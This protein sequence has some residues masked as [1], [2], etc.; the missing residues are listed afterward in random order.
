MSLTYEIGSNQIDGVEVQLGQV[1]MLEV[2]IEGE[3]DQTIELT[4]DQ[5]IVSIVLDVTDR[6]EGIHP[7]RFDLYQDEVLISSD[8]TVVIG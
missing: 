5:R 4:E 1:D 7:V 3:L 6:A 2:F 8:E